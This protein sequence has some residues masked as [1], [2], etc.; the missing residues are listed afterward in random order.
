MVKNYNSK[1]RSKYTLLF[2]V[3]ISVSFLLV[4]SS[5]KYVRYFTE[6]DE[7]YYLKYATYISTNGIG[8]FPDLFKDYTENKNNWFYPRPL[9]IGY[10]LL[11]VIS[12]KIFGDTFLSLSLLS[13]V[14]Y[15]AFL[16]VSFYFTRKYFD[17]KIAFLLTILL[18]F[19]PL[20]MAMARRAL[21]DSTANLFYILSIWLFFDLLSRRSNLKYVLF[22]LIFSFT[23]LVKEPAVLLSPV[24]ILYI[25]IHK[26]LLKN[27]VHIKDILATTV[28]PFA[29][30]GLVYMSCAGDFSYVLNTVKTILILQKTNQYSILYGSGPWFRYLIDFMLVSPWVCILSMGFIFYCLTLKELDSRISYFLIIFVLIFIFFNLFEK[31]CQICD[32]AGYA[33][34]II[35]D[36]YADKNSRD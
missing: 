34:E 16:I 12:M 6:A 33:D 1:S 9:R 10:I 29:I 24:F 22:V 31:K 30:V 19:S 18:A 36:P 4:F 27:P 8:N 3:V 32:Y 35:C 26:Y 5:L 2:I 17:E 21:Q 11:S 23:I 25:L 13:L 28:Y 20:N 14:S 7:G 15:L